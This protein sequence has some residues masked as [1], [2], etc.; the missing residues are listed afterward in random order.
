MVYTRGSSSDYDRFAEVTGDP[1]WSWNALQPYVK[2]VLSCSLVVGWPR[3][4]IICPQHEGFTA[5][6]DNHSTVGQFDPSVHGFNGP[7]L[8]TLPGILNPSIDSRVITAAQQ[9]RGDFAFNLDM[10]SGNPLGVGARHI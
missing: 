7:I 8:T 10:N 5:P 3:L 1:G 6:V 4:T 2:K 9:L